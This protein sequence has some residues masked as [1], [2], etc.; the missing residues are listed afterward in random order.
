[1][2][3]ENNVKNDFYKMTILDL[4]NGS[5]MDDMRLLLKEYE[6]R[7]M[8]EACAGIHKAIDNARFWTLLN[9]TEERKD[10]HDKIIINFDEDE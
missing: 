7:E 5:S 1:M 4:E 6:E 8:Y 2:S 3:K 10:L 9:M